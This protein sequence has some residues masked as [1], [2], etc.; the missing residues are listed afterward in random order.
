VDEMRVCRTCGETFMPWPEN[1]GYA[2]ECR[3]CEADRLGLRP[4]QDGRGQEEGE[5]YERPD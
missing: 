4:R 5:S 1:R 2:D 3:D